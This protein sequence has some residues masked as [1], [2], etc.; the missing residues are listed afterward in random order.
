MPEIVRFA[1]S[2]SFK[3]KQKRYSFRPD[4]FLFPES[5]DVIAEQS[6]QSPLLAAAYLQ[7]MGALHPGG[8]FNETRNH[9]FER[10]LVEL[11]RVSADSDFHNYFVARAYAYLDKR[12]AAIELL[13]EPTNTYEEALLEVLNGNLSELQALRNKLGLT[14]LDFM[15]LRDLQLLESHYTRN[16][17][18]YSL[19]QFA[20]RHP[21]WTPFIYRAMQ[22]FT[23]WANYSAATVKLGLESLVPE[24][25]VS[26]E[27]EITKQAVTGES[28]SEIDLVRL[29][30]RHIESA[31]KNLASKRDRYVTAHDVL[32]LATSILVANHLREVDE[33]L[34][35]R[36]IPSA[37][38]KEISEFDSI[39]SGHPAVILLKGR[40][41]NALAAKS[42][43]ETER[44]NLTQA[45]AEALLDGFALTGQLTKDAVEVARNYRQTLESSS[46]ENWQQSAESFNVTYSERYFEW[47]RG[48]AWYQKIPSVELHFGVTQ[49]CI[50]YVWSSYYCVEAEIEQ[51]SRISPTDMKSRDEILQKYAHRYHGNR[52]RVRSEVA[53]Q[54]QRGD[55]NAE[56]EALKTAI[57]A[58]SN[59]WS[60]YEALGNLHFRR[61]DYELAQRAWLS[62]P[63]FRA[64]NT[65]I[66]VS[67]ASNADVA[68]SYLY[69]IGQYE[70]ALPLLEIAAAS[71]T[72]SANSMTSAERAALVQGDLELAGQ[73]AAARVRRYNSQYGMRDLLQILHIL[74]ENEVAWNIFDQAQA[75]RQNSQM[76][77]GALVGH[78]MNSATIDDISKWLESSD[79]RKNAFTTASGRYPLPL[80][81]APRYL[82]M[83][84][85][86]DRIPGDALA[87][88]V[89]KAHTRQAPKV[90]TMS[91]EQPQTRPRPTYV[92]DPDGRYMH[93]SRIVSPFD[94]P[95]FE[96]EEVLSPRLA[97]LAEAMTAFLQDDFG[98]AYERF[99]YFA[100]VYLLEEYLPYYA[101]A[102][103]KTNNAQHL[104]DALSFREKRLEK[105]R[106]A[107]TV[108]SSDRGYRFDEDLT[109]AVLAAL[110]NRPEDSLGYLK[111]ALNN[112]PYIG[113]RS[114]YP[115][116]QIVDLSDRFYRETGD[117]RYRDFALKLSRRHT[118]VLPMY[119]WA[120][121]VV[122][123][124][125]P[126]LVERQN[127]A[128]SGLA[129]DPLSARGQRLPQ[130]LVDEAQ[131][132]LESRG[133]PYLSRSGSAT[134]EGV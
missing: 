92:E 131:G 100:H 39:F 3:P 22:D 113:D 112:R 30:L 31:E 4:E 81:L 108:G 77:S 80:E 8:A 25:V 26:L 86:M 63:D 97:I 127:A 109:Y 65:D 55:Q 10:S 27:H 57:A 118:V 5:L 28:P 15:T 20:E 14:A 62:F 122:A 53:S 33:N 120:Y 114:V 44:Q 79:A 129:L 29:S 110:D 41:L 119:S 74:G 96:I 70:L 134:E 42:T 38:L 83:A 102:A 128:A 116:Y 67:L 16:T 126:S 95:E 35:K 37:A 19:E 54:R 98:N 103:L 101:Y 73:W 58:G 104:P 48:E 78:R 111:K 87:P 85:T 32:D 51:Q 23:T 115:M 7:L 123:E 106:L 89:L 49:G 17:D 76:W 12:P 124:Y 75:A 60:I 125:S 91:D 71:R 52:Q 9:L 130:K 43:G 59:D 117:A 21:D 18:A 64:D 47:P 84:G 2:E 11:T 66:T 105:I 68:A 132:I 34:T 46:A 107:E 90:F 36:V 94:T 50:D 99:N 61:G 69:W 40:A 93:D 82:L 133:A 6:R 88:A 13:A 56:I 1:V 121:F 24:Q 45:G 72:G